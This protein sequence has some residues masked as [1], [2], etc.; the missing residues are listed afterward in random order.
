MEGGDEGGF[1]A[2]R[3]DTGAALAGHV[4]LDPAA[5]QRGLYGP[6]RGARPGVRGGDAARARETHPAQSAQPARGGAV[7]AGGRGGKLEGDAV[8]AVC[9]LAGGGQ[10]ALDIALGEN[11]AEFA[12]VLRNEFDGKRAAEL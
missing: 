1:K 5:P 4:A 2:R 10:A 9:N 3:D 12:A 8:S 7:G 11:H 6:D